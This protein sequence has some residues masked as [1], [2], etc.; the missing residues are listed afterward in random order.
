MN[1]SVAGLEVIAFFCGMNKTL[2]LILEVCCGQ[3]EASYGR[4]CTFRLGAFFAL[5]I[6]FNHCQT[7]MCSSNQVV[8]I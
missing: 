6:A 7:W 5:Q 8:T 2:R 3:V 1:W 4:T